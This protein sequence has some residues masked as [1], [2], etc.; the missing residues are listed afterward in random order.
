MK[1]QVQQFPMNPNTVEIA[2][3]GAMTAKICSL[4]WD[5]RVDYEPG[6]ELTLDLSCSGHSVSGS[7]SEGPLTFD[8]AGGLDIQ[9]AWARFEREL[10]ALNIEYDL[11][12]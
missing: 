2:F 10:I 6:Q 5:C 12:E 9:A 1:P 8:L 4:G 3:L 11:F 7:T